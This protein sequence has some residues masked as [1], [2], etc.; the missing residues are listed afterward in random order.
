MYLR[1]K[2]QQYF[3]GCGCTFLGKEILLILLIGV[4]MPLT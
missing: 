2:A 4:I 3:L 1:V